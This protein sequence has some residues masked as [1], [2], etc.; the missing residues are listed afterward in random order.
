[1][2]ASDMVEGLSSLGAQLRDGLLEKAV[3]LSV[4][5]QHLEATVKFDQSGAEPGKQ[6]EHGGELALSFNKAALLDHMNGEESQTIK[7]LEKARQFSGAP[8]RLRSLIQRR[9]TVVQNRPHPET[10]RFDLA[11]SKRFDKPASAVELRMEFFS[12]FGLSQPNRTARVE[13]IDEI[14]TVGVYRWAGDS[15]RNEQWSQLIRQFKAGDAAMPALFGRILAEHVQAT[16]LCKTWLGEV[17]YVIPVPAA[18]LRTAERGIDIVAR[19][20][21]HLSWRLGIL[22]RFD[23]LRREEGSVRSR[24]ISSK[25]ELASQYRFNVKNAGDID[26]LTVMLLD[27]VM[28]RGYTTGVCASLLREF[29]CARVVLLVLA[30]SESSL[31]SSR[32]TGEL[33]KQVGS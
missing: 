4:R 10:K 20:S 5:G 11:I 26:G 14:S 32:H 30:Q 12:R 2:K 22:L 8:T 13:G 33:D 28:N 9:L 31:Q 1:M 27:D 29:G 17:D 15:K 16:A 3:D 18:A 24:F 25:S 21:E 6:G 19:T 7:D 23:F